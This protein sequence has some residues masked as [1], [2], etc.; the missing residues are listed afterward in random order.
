MAYNAAAFGVLPYTQIWVQTVLGMSPMQGALALVPLAATA[1]VVSAV[2]GRLLHGAPHRLV[3]GIGLLLIGG[4]TLGQAVLTA[5]SDWTALVAGLTVAGVGVGLVSPALGGAALASVPPRNA[6]MAGGAVNTF[7]QLGYAFGVAG[8][9]TIITARMASSLRDAEVAAPGQAAHTLAGGGA[10]ALR[11]SVTDEVMRTASASGLN[12][13]AVVAG[14]LGLLAGLAVLRWVRT[15]PQHKDQ[16]DGP[17]DMGHDP[18]ARNNSAVT[19][20]R[21]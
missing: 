7:R 2:S 6:G 1:F 15:A 20:E 17:H 8:F 10:E 14:V 16:H 21:P 13:G 4:G 11:P 3:I 5:G 12:T 18:Q 19:V 9:G